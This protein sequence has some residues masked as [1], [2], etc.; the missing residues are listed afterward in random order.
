MMK[1]D[2]GNTILN[3]IYDAIPYI[4]I[5]FDKDIEIM[6]TDT[7]KVLYYQG[8]KEIDGH[9]Q[10][11][12]EVGKFVKQAMAIGQVEIKIIPEDFIGVA[13]KSYMI[14][15]KDQNKVVGSIA[16]GKSLSKK[17]GVTHIAQELITALA[18]IE[19][20]INQISSDV[21]NLANMNNDI[22]E[23]THTAKTMAKDTDSIVNFIKTI[24]SQTNLLGLNASIEAAR[25][26]EAG[27]GFNVV[28]QEISKLSKSSNDSIGKIEDVIKNIATSIEKINDKVSQA[29]GISSKQSSALQEMNASIWQLNATAQ[30]LGKL[31]E[32]L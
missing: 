28:A 23:E 32:D 31:A 26:G 14:P 20:G 5:F 8:S 19:Q 21:L 29:E 10:V 4:H 11:G 9:I 18:N 2:Y 30:L 17:S 6:L 1:Q 3:S 27:R 25:V 12:S 15:I 13:F 22:V 16:I 24:S 7:N